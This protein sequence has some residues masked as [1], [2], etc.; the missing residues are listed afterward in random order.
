MSKA[1]HDRA[2]PR[3][4]AGPTVPQRRP[5]RI[6]LVGV[7]R[8][9]AR[10][11]SR[12]LLSAH[13]SPT[14]FGF[15][16]SPGAAQE[17]LERGDWDC[18]VLWTDEMTPSEEV[19]SMVGRAGMNSVP[20]VVVGPGPW[21]DV[22]PEMVRHGASDYLLLEDLDDVGLR[23]AV[24][25]AIERGRFHSS[26]LPIKDPLTGLPN[27]VLFV[28]RLRLA[29]ARRWRQRTDVAVIFIDLDDFK[30]VNDR[31]GH[32]M[33]DSVLVAVADSL[34]N[35]FRASDTVARLAGDEFGVVCEGV[36]LARALDQLRKTARCAAAI[37]VERDGA[38]VAVAAS[39]GVACDSDIDTPGGL[40][41]AAD[42]AMYEEKSQRTV[43]RRFAESPRTLSRVHGDSRA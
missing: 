3:P 14:A 24:R 37:R 34:R 16:K 35:A 41:R 33:G 40:M 4:A 8:G 21:E 32:A 19:R 15:A 5:T 10:Q 1:D 26:E 43:G 31:Y 20:V 7:S 13:G 17:L 11:A 9:R 30:R 28:D 38:E 2:D 27:R 18:I 23:H 6:L 12:T 42:R 36:G 25:L 39:V 29:L 22:A